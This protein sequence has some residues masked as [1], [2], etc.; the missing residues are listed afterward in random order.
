MLDI[1]KYMLP[2]PVGTWAFGPYNTDQTLDKPVVR[3]F[4]RN[5]RSAFDVI[6][7]ENFLHECFVALGHKYG[8]VPVVQLLASSTSVRVS[9]WHGQPYDP[10]YIP[11]FTIGFPSNMTFRQRTLNAVSAFFHTWVNRVVYITR[12]QTLMDKHF[13]YPGYDSRPSLVEMLRNVSLTLI[14]SHSAAVGSPV[15]MVPSFINVAGM[16]CTPSNLLPKV[17]KCFNSI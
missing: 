4:I 2:E 6:L 9:Q 5:D 7:F 8:G 10:S 12:Q 17:K 16:H 11:E 14:N 15:P 1:A 3:N 13:V